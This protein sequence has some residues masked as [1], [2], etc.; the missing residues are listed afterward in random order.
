MRRRA[1]L[2]D[3]VDKHA[4]L[5]DLD[6]LDFI[7][8]L[9]PRM[10]GNP[11]ERPEHLA[12]LADV[13]ER[14]NRGE[15]VMVLVSIPPQFGKSE[16]MCHGGSK[17]L[18]NHGDW[19]LLYVSY[20]DDLAE[21]KSRLMRDYSR[22]C[23]V[24]MREDADSVGTWLTPTGGGLRARGIFSPITGNPARVIIVDDPHKNRKDAES[25]LMRERVYQEFNS[26]VR[27]RAHPETSFVVCHARWHTDDL[28]G[29]LS[30]ERDENG[31]PVW[32]VIN[33]PAILSNGQPLWHRRPLSFLEPIRRRDERD[34]NSLYMGEPKSQGDAIFRGVRFFTQLPFR[35]SVGKGIDLAYTTKTSACYSCGVTMLAFVDT[36]TSDPDP[37]YYVV[38][39]Q[40]AQ[41]E[42]RD[43]AGRL[44]AIDAMW[45]GSAWHFYGSAQEVGLAPLM[46]ELGVAFNAEKAVEDKLTRAL[47][48]ATAWNRGR[49][50][51][52][53]NMGALLG[54]RASKE[55]RE[56]EVSWLK[57]FVDE[58]GTFTGR[59][60]ET[61]D[62]VDALASAFESCRQMTPSPMSVVEDGG[63]RWENE[64]R[65]FG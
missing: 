16:L 10:T 48:I 53:K 7:P 1:A 26:S 15:R 47:P 34:W 21:E 44:R 4:R 19:P 43:L 6:L 5:I 63:S 45:P 12:R 36:T 59:K 64:G 49:V 20:G 30:K 22:L 56:S 60:G 55:A 46:H 39:V 14:I 58:L 9:T 42:P 8:A 61:N 24:E 28:I 18:A 17:I 2:K 23:G 33:L 32:E 11:T 25:A 62:Q 50:L 29:R 3:R 54:E 41:C 65:G 35:Y 52:P 38:D 31:K 57:P 51:V 40:R 13:F 27:T 37:W